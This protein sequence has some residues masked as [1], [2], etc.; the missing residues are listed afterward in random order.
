MFTSWL[1]DQHVCNTR[2][3]AETQTAKQLALRQ[4]AGQLARLGTLH[5]GANVRKPT[6]MQVKF[7]LVLATTKYLGDALSCACLYPCLQFAMHFALLLFLFCLLIHVVCKADQ[8]AH[9]RATSQWLLAFASVHMP[10][11]KFKQLEV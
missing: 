1:A 8:Q 6:E 3:H 2:P 7:L 9:A 4:D 11:P 5:G 10:L